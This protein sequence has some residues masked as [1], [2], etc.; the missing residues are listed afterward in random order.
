MRVPP[1][2]WFIIENIIKMDNLEVLF[3]ETSIR[4]MVKTIVKTMSSGIFSWLI[5]VNLRVIHPI[6]GITKYHGRLQNNGDHPPG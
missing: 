3:Q 2:G 6:M 4:A 1:Y 5:Y